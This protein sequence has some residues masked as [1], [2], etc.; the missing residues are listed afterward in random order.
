MRIPSMGRVGEEARGDRSADPG[1][2]TR[3]VDRGEHVHE[4][5]ALRESDGRTGASSVCRIID[6]DLEAQ[7]VRDPEDAQ[8]PSSCD[9]RERVVR[10][11]VHQDTR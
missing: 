9:T 3:W 7:D 8:L 11:D 2:I 4:A 5:S 1:W 6:V 10:V